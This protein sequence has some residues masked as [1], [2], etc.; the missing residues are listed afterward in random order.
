MFG[1]LR[2][3]GC[4]FVV[5]LLAIGGWLTRDLWWERA[6]GRPPGP[7]REW[8]TARAAESPDAERRL[9]A[10]SQ[11]QGPVFA[12]FTA[13]DIG[14]LVLSA[15]GSRL[16]STVDDVE[17]SVHGDAVAIRASVDLTALRSVEALGPVASLLTSRQRLTLVGRPSVPE[18]GRGAFEVTEVKVGGVDVPAP[19][20]GALLREL[21]R[22]RGAPGRASGGS[23]RTITFPVPLYIGDIRVARG[24]VILYKSTP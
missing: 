12:T 4:L 13:A 22:A 5:V 1:C 11:K 14:A 23:G 21:D 9:R 19:A 18:R 17:T 10:L 3:I 20:I 16:P 15:G 7:A 24:K 8:T 2:R 6:T